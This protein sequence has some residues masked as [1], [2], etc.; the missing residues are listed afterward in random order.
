[1]TG[2]YEEALAS[3]QAALVLRYVGMDEEVRSLVIGMMRLV[4]G[5]IAETPLVC[6]PDGAEGKPLSRTSLLED[7][8]WYSDDLFTEIIDHALYVTSEQRKKYDLTIKAIALVELAQR[9]TRAA[10]HG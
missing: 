1:M 8:R 2:K 4:D 5:L 6:A 3:N 9:E 10:R 7:L